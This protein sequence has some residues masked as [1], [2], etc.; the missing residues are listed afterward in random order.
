MVHPI[1][2]A[3]PLCFARA[4]SVLTL[5]MASVGLGFISIILAVLICGRHALHVAPVAVPAGLA[6]WALR[7]TGMGEL[8]IRESAL[9]EKLSLFPSFIL[10]SVVWS[11]LIIVS[12]GAAHYAG[13][14]FFHLNSKADEEGDTPNAVMVNQSPSR[15]AN[16]WQHSILSLAVSCVIAGVLL[17]L[18]TRSGSTEHAGVAVGAEPLKGQILFSVFIS[19]FLG[20]LACHQWLQGRV[21]DFLPSPLVVSTVFYFW[22][23]RSDSFATVLAD[24]AALFPSRLLSAV[25]CPLPFISIGSLG[26]LWGYWYSVQLVHTRKNLRLV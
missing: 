13:R 3:E 22:A 15:L 19:F 26:L 20:T 9:G 10:E 25:I 7:S 5:V 1:N 18:F 16:R 12:Y 14:W 17:C 23:Y 24:S 21:Y 11:L 4:G 8:L 2:P 6:A